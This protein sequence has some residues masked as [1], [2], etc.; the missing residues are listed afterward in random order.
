MDLATAIV[1]GLGTLAL[2]AGGLILHGIRDDITRLQE[3]H[4]KIEDD[5]ANL[6]DRLSNRIADIATKVAILLDRDRRKRLED[7]E[8]ETD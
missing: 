5:I 8:Q 1:G 6:G 2:S 7:Y 4:T 3:A